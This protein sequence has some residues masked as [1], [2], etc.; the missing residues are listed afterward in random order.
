[1][2]SGKYDHV[3]G[4][5]EMDGPAQIKNVSGEHHIYI[6]MRYTSKEGGGS[7]ATANPISVAGWFFGRQNLHRQI[8]GLA[9]PSDGMPN[10]L[11]LA[12]SLVSNLDEMIR[13]FTGPN[14]RL[15]GFGCANNFLADKSWIG[16]KS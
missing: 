2:T 5:F 16:L 15:K 4:Y 12:T 10:L 6:P 9:E 13:I 14:Q 11:S 1:M 8:Y 7:S 3:T